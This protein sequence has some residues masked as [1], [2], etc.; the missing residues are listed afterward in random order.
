MSWCEVYFRS[1][2]STNNKTNFED[3]NRY[4][5]QFINRFFDYSSDIFHLYIN[6]IYFINYCDK[7]FPAKLLYVGVLID[8]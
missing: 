6:M 8:L 2:T 5:P 7:Y 1:L 3:T 4:K